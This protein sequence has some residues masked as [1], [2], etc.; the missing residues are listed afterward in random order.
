MQT[1]ANANENLSL[2]ELI[3]VGY[4]GS[5]FISVLPSQDSLRFFAQTATYNLKTNVINA[6]DVKIIKVADAA[7]FPDSGKVCIMKDAQMQV[8]HNANI[9]A[10]TST[11]FHSFYKADVS[12]AT[13]HR[14]TGKGSTIIRTGSGRS[15]RSCSI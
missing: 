13:R 6:Q 11:K 9:I 2:A 14:Y 1:G 5:E 12:I 10:N 15:S 4:K 3:D 7:I 8:L